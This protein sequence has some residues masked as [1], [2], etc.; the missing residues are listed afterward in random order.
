MIKII[1]SVNFERKVQLVHWFIKDI[2]REERNTTVVWNQ[3]LID[4]QTQ[5]KHRKYERIDNRI[6]NMIKEFNLV[7]LQD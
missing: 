1:G 4:T 7:S 3:V 2:I 5:T 6:E